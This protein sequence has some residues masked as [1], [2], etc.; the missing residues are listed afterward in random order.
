[1]IQKNVIMAEIKIE[2]KPSLFPWVLGALILAGLIYFI[3]LLIKS[4]NTET[5]LSKI[6]TISP[7]PPLVEDL[8]KGNLPVDNETAGEINTNE[9]VATGKVEVKTDLINLNEDDAV[10]TY[11]SFLKEN[12]KMDIH[13]EYSNTALLSLIR[14]VEQVAKDNN[15]EIQTN[16]NEARYSAN[17]ITKDPYKV[18]HADHIKKASLLITNVIRTIQEKSFSDMAQ[19]LTNLQRKANNI[20]P[21]LETLN[22]KNKV[23]SF[24]NQAALVLTKMEL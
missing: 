20:E 16:L 11:I 19:D 9:A 4:P 21:G 1:M 17:L 18:N 23:K 2:K 5:E 6:E 14:A 13:H 3:F 7:A 10:T 15:I 22:Q 8:E 12:K 24:F